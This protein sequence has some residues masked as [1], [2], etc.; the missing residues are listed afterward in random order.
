MFYFPDDLSKLRQRVGSAPT[1]PGPMGPLA[2]PGGAL[3]GAS[4]AMMTNNLFPTGHP[5]PPRQSLPSPARSPRSQPP[6]SAAQT[7][8]YTG[9]GGYPPTAG[10]TS[11]P[12]TPRPQT[13]GPS[14]QQ[15]PRPSMV[16]DGISD[17][18]ILPPQMMG[19]SGPMGGLAGDA[20]ADVVMQNRGPS[21]TPRPMSQA[22]SQGGARTVREMSLARDSAH[23]QTPPHAPHP[24]YVL[25]TV[26]VDIAPILLMPPQCPFKTIRQ[27][28]SHGTQCRSQRRSAWRA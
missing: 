2:L 15:A 17:P 21:Q 24:S 28:A 25:V 27:F 6:H 4:H 3:S 19:Q 13:A 20:P 26:T 11:A 8:V 5:L 23:A 18:S 9:P 14:Y 16:P 12:P 7:P 10:M 1:A 22:G